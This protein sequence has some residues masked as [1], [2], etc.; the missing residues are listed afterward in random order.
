MVSGVKQRD[1]YDFPLPPLPP[2]LSLTL[3]LA[4]VQHFGATFLPFLHVL[5]LDFLRLPAFPLARLLRKSASPQNW[6]R[7]KGQGN[8]GNRVSY[9]SGSVRSPD[10]LS[11]QG[12]TADDSAEILCHEGRFSRDPLS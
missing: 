3:A 4:A 6:G 10:R 8:R 5:F 12:D 11:R 2:R 1:C 7:G 9:V